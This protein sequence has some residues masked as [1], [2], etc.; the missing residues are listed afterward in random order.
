MQRRQLP[1]TTMIPMTTTALKRASSDAI[2]SKHWAGDGKI[3]SK[4]TMVMS[5]ATMKRSTKAPKS[6]TKTPQMMT[7]STPIRP[8]TDPKQSRTN[9]IKS[10][11]P[12]VERLRPNPRAE[13]PAMRAATSTFQ[14]KMKMMHT[15]RPKRR[16]A[17][18]RLFGRRWVVGANVATTITMT[19]IT[20]MTKMGKMLPQSKTTTM[21]NWNLHP[22]ICRKKTERLQKMRQP[23]TKRVTDQSPA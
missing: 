6:K 17:F 11:K 3:R 14:S 5:M 20:Q 13:C 7:M 15:R 16:R 19:T 1:T 12:S 18:S 9:G 23:T 10:C 4:R 21:V 8:E 22:T 2:P